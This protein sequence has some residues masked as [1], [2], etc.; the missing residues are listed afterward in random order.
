MTF[1]SSPRPR[2]RRYMPVIGIARLWRHPVSILAPP[3]G[4]ALLK[5]DSQTSQV[6]DGFNPRPARGRGAT[7]RPRRPGRAAPRR[8]NPRPARG[9][10]ATRP[11]SCR[12]RAASP[13]FNPRPARGRGATAT[14]TE[15]VRR[16]FERFQSSPRPRARRYLARRASRSSPEPSGFNPRPARGRG[17]TLCRRTACHGYCPC[18]NPRPARGRG[19][20]CPPAR[21]RRP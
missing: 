18:F 11:A 19:A 21:R 9:R 15:G 8:F 5:S 14:T 2:A 12:T 7:R 16:A 17:A 4:E 20:T 10:G 1:Q 3:E 13:R 6:W